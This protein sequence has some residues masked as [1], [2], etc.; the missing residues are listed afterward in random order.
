MAKAVLSQLSLY[1]YW[2]ASA[3]CCGPSW[4]AS[5]VAGGRYSAVLYPMATQIILVRESILLSIHF[6]I[7]SALTINPY[8]VG[9]APNGRENASIQK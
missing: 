4:P 5:S 7:L 8:Y 1:P 9:S 6:V 3:P 2:G